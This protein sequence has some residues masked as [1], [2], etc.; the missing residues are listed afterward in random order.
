MEGR[1]TPHV[2][3]APRANCL[4]LLHQDLTPQLTRRLRE[5]TN[6]GYPLILDRENGHG[7]PPFAL[8]AGLRLYG[9]GGLF[10]ARTVLAVIQQ[11]IL[12]ADA[13]GE[14][15]LDLRGLDYIALAS[16]AAIIHGTQAFRDRGGIVRV[17]TAGSY[18]RLREMT[19]RA[20]ADRAHL[21]FV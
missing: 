4:V 15:S 9:E 16:W 19:T 17:H 2:D 20:D 1:R 10:M 8:G 5:L 7:P 21:E 18:R 11:S 12:D 3:S 6:A 14:F 13:D